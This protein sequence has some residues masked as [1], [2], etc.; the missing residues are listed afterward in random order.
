MSYIYRSVGC[1]LNVFGAQTALTD[2]HSYAVSN[3]TAVRQ[4]WARVKCPP[5]PLSFC[6]V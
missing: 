5:H 1:D 4:T 3:R 6:S 2:P